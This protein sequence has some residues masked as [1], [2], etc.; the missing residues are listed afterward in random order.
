MSATLAAVQALVEMDDVVVSAHGEK[1]LA[2]DGIDVTDLTATIRAARVVEDYPIYA[3]GPCVL[4]LQ[5][6]AAGQPVHVLWGIRTG[7]TQPAVLITAY[8][9]DPVKWSADF[10]TRIP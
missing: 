6:D 3:K 9:P 5:R 2:N 7:T 4:V 10:M 8:R 1:E